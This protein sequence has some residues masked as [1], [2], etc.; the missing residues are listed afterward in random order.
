LQACPTPAPT[1]NWCNWGAYGPCT[2]STGFCT[3]RFF[4][5]IQTRTRECACPPP[6]AGSFTCPGASSQTQTCAPVRTQL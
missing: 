1:A 5:G 6:P 3:D 2:P 4:P